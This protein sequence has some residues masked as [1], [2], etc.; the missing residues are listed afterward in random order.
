MASSAQYASV[1]ATGTVVISTA[2][3]SLTGTGTLGTLVATTTNGVRVDDIYIKALGATTDGMIRFFIQNG[4]DFFLVHEVDV[5]TI[6][7]SATVKSFASVLTELGWVLSPTCQLKV[8][9]E[10]GESFA[11]SFLRGGAL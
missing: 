1:P 4:A 7:P 5:T 9:T 6:T 3:S 11:I 10:K 2:N 8:S